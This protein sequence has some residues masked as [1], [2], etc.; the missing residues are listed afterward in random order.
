MLSIVERLLIAQSNIWVHSSIGFCRFPEPYTFHRESGH[1]ACGRFIIL[2][3]CSGTSWTK[4]RENYCWHTWAYS[5][6]L[7]NRRLT[8]KANA[9]L[10]SYSKTLSVLH[11]LFMIRMTYE[12]WM[13]HILTQSTPV[14]RIVSYFPLKDLL[15][16]ISNGGWVTDM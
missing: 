15:K 3:H 7:R 16:W 11:V 9:H 6:I 14:V 13:K 1:M 2:L 8:S 4:I 5:W 10:L 12:V